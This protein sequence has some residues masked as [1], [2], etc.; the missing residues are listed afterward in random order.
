MW[1]P[2]GYKNAIQHDA[3]TCE[4]FEN[5]VGWPKKRPSEPNNF[6]GSVLTENHQL[7]EIC[8][9]KCRRNPNWEYC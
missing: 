6:M 4:Q 8:P 3:Y 5:S 1:N 2:W 7:T 9:I